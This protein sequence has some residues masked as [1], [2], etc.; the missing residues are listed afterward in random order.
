MIVSTSEYLPLSKAAAVI[1]ITSGRLRQM[2]R[3]R[4]I[5]FERVDAPV[6]ANGYY[7]RIPR[8][9]VRRLKKD[10]PTVGR[11]RIGIA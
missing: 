6:N 8:A 4:E 5:D 7:Y 10:V 1:G 2:I 3:D 11:P 9:E